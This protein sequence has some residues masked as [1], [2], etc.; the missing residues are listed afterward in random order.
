MFSFFKLHQR[1]KV[2]LP[3]CRLR[4]RLSLAEEGWLRSFH[5]R[6]LW[7]KTLL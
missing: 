7:Q 6:R 4:S 1:E 3:R 5:D 2:D